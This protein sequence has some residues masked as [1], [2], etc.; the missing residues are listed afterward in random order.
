MRAAERGKQVAALVELKA[1]FDEKKNIGWARELENAGVH[2]VYGLKGL[3][4]HTKTTLVVREEDDGIRRYC[5]IGTGNYNPKTA[6]LYDDLGLLTADPEI[7]SDL[8]Q[9]FNVL[10]GFARD[11]HFSRLLVAPNDVRPGIAALIANEASHGAAGRIVL[12]MNSLVDPDLIDGLYAA[13]Q[14]GNQIDLIIRG[15]CCL[16][17]GVPGLSENIRVRSIVGRYLEHSRIYHFAHGRDGAPITYIGSADLMPR[18]LDRRVEALV[19][20][21]DPRLRARI[22]QIIDVQLADD[23]LAWTLQPDSTWTKVRR[24]VGV[25]THDRLEQLA[26]ERRG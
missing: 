7:G 12:K 2:V 8:T 15:I 18:N 21:D 10:T 22:D 11:P 3:K 16:R 19:P 6:R 23:E 20:I 26:L 14:A 1:R 17:P 5:H 13:S 25:D 9:L 4:I 24:V